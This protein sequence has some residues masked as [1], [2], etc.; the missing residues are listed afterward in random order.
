MHKCLFLWSHLTLDWKTHCI[1]SLVDP[2]E[3]KDEGDGD[4]EHPFV[5]VEIKIARASQVEVEQVDLYEVEAKVQV[6]PPSLLLFFCLHPSMPSLLSWP[7]HSASL[8]ILLKKDW[9]WDKSFTK[10]DENTI[11]T[12]LDAKYT[13]PNTKYTLLLS[14]PW[15]STSLHRE[16][17]KCPSLS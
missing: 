11:S 3:D 6:Q 8:H 17:E 1:I 16:L 5:E 13:I 15:H 12:I 4:G 10:L 9:S 2:G 14:W 7:W